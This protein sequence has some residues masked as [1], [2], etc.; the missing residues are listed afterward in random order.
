MEAQCQQFEHDHRLLNTNLGIRGAKVEGFS[1]E[2]NPIVA[3]GKD[4]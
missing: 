2:R 3:T 1:G 4:A